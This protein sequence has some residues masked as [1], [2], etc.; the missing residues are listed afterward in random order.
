MK[1]RLG[2]ID[3]LKGLAIILVVM[4][5][6]VQFCIHSSKHWL[7][8]D[9]YVFHMP[10]FFFLSGLVVHGARQGS[11]RPL[12]VARKARQ[13]L[14]PLLCWGGLMTLF[15]GESYLDF[16][17]HRYFYG[18]WYLWTL[19]LLYAIFYLMD[20][21]VA[22]LKRWPTAV[23]ILLSGCIWLITRQ[24]GGVI[25][26]YPAVEKL[27]HIS[28]LQEFY[29]FFFL[30]VMVTRFNLSAWVVKH[31]SKVLTVALIAILPLLYLYTG[32]DVQLSWSLLAIAIIMAFYALFLR[33]D[34][35]YQPAVRR[36]LQPLEYI[37]RHTLII[38]MV[39]FFLVHAL[40]IESMAAVLDATS[41][42]LP[43][44]ALV[45]VISM[46]LIGLCLLAEKVITRGWLLGALLLGKDLKSNNK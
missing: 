12:L 46:V 25:W 5:H 16:L 17:Q 41:N 21:F 10:L 14:I 15:L 30:G 4:G 39:H 13:L 28:T 42:Y 36:W 22:W 37:G 2:Y 7:Y 6:V 45:F 24:L 18:Y 9:I 40:N 3:Q 32:R 38:Y 35:N 33:T 27:A 8:E 31:Q 44:A 43:L 23:F 29:P 19:F 1:Q 26:N 34:N 11:S 20:G